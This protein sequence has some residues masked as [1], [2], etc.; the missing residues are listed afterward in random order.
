M[1]AVLTPT[2]FFSANSRFPLQ[3][4]HLRDFRGPYPEPPKTELTDTNGFVAYTAVLQRSAPSLKYVDID[5]H[6]HCLAGLLSESNELQTINPYTGPFAEGLAGNTSL[7]HF[8]LHV[9]HP[10]VT[11]DDQDRQQLQA[12]LAQPTILETLTLAGLTSIL[13]DAPHN[14][15]LPKLRFLTLDGVSIE[16]T[17]G[18]DSLQSLIR[19]CDLKSLAIVHAPSTSDGLAGV[20]DGCARA[21]NLKHLQILDLSHNHL[22]RE[23]MNMVFVAILGFCSKI[24]KLYLQGNQGLDL[25]AIPRMPLRSTLTHLEVSDVSFEVVEHL[26]KAASAAGS[27][28]ALRSILVRRLTSEGPI[29][30]ESFDRFCAALTEK[31]VLETLLIVP[32]DSFWPLTHYALD[33]NPLK[34]GPKEYFWNDAVA[35]IKALG[36]GLDKNK[37]N[38][39]SL[40]TFYLAGVSDFERFHSDN[41]IA[42]RIPE[43]APSIL[44]LAPTTEELALMMPEA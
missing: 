35:W 32:E 23:H 13:D 10:H 43:D 31:S 26:V 3:R 7:L 20:L 33:F 28:P 15:S 19:S 12:V 30:K 17:K 24:D 4:R 14:I 37:E 38:G 34:M 44:A 42:I 8:A 36:K 18:A 40:T 25:S 6:S 27:F 16:S 39:S 11:Q 21:K 22:S 2:P 9:V 29:A 1:P 41:P 5:L